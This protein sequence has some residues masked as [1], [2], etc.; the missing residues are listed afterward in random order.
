MRQIIGW[1][2]FTNSHLIICSMMSESEDSSPGSML[3]ESGYDLPYL[4]PDGE[5]SDGFDFVGLLTGASSPEDMHLGSSSSESEDALR[6]HPLFPNFFEPPANHPV[7]RGTPDTVWSRL[8]DSDDYV[9]HQVHQLTMFPTPLF[10]P[11][12][13]GEARDPQGPPH[14]PPIGHP[15]IQRAFLTR[16]IG[17]GITSWDTLATL[18]SCFCITSPFLGLPYYQMIGQILSPNIPLFNMPSGGEMRPIA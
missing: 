1:L 18:L 10:P 7:V 5:D 3:G 15:V 4:S 12:M 6:T 8:W 9:K 13:L 14:L 17:S 11:S 16:A 2:V